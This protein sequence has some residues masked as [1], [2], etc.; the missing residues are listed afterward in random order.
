MLTT[1]PGVDDV[2][3]TTIV[4][5]PGGIVAPAAIVTCVG[6][7]VTPVHVPVLPD[8]VVTPAGMMSVNAADKVSGVA[9]PLPSVIV[10][11]AVPPATIVAGAMDL[12]SVAVLVER[13][14]LS[15]AL[16]DAPEG[17]STTVTVFTSGSVARFAANDTGT[18]NVSEFAFPAASC[19]PVAP[20]LV[21]PA[22]P[23]TVPQLA[24]PVAVHVTLPLSAT[25]AG[26][27]SLIVMSAASETPALRTVIV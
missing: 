2:I 17:R 20:K 8:V 4:Q 16:P 10:S 11:V 9:L 24:L 18:R 12:A 1:V 25:P 5:P 19:A 23:E 7:T 15:D 27:A 22:V 3:V 13:V 21:W 14:S 26:S 6:V